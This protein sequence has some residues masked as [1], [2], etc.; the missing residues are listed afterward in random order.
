MHPEDVKSKAFVLES[1]QDTGFGTGQPY[2]NHQ[3][4]QQQQQQQL[5]QQAFQEQQHL[6]PQ[7]QQQSLYHQQQQQQQ[8]YHQQQQQQQQHQQHY[9]QQQQ[10]HFVRQTAACMSV[11]AEAAKYGNAAAIR[12]QLPQMEWGDNLTQVASDR[13][14]GVVVGGSP[15]TCPPTVLNSAASSSPMDLGGHS[16][17]HQQQQVDVVVGTAG[18]GFVHGTL[19]FATVLGGAEQRRTSVVHGGVQQQQ[20]LVP[21]PNQYSTFHDQLSYVGGGGGGGSG[22]GQ[23]TQAHFGVEPGGYGTVVQSMVQGS[24]GT[25]VIRTSPNACSPP[26]GGGTAGGGSVVALAATAYGRMEPLAPHRTTPTHVASFMGTGSPGGMRLNDMTAAATT[27]MQT[28]SPG[29][30]LLSQ[31]ATGAPL[32][33]H[34]EFV[35]P[36][37]PASFPSSVSLPTSSPHSMTIVANDPLKG[38]ATPASLYGGPIDVSLESEFTIPKVETG[39]NNQQQQQQQHQQQQQLGLSLP[40]TTDPSIHS[41]A[42]RANSSGQADDDEGEHASEDEDGSEADSEPLEEVMPTDP[43]ATAKTEALDECSLVVVKQ[44]TVSEHPG[45]MSSLGGGGEVVVAPPKRPVKHVRFVEPA[46]E[47]SFDGMAGNRARG[48]VSPHP[49]GI[50]GG[51][52]RDG[53]ED[54][55]EMDHLA[56]MENLPPV[57]SLLVE[58]D[59]PLDDEAEDDDDDDEDEDDGGGDDDDDDDDYDFECDQGKRSRKRRTPASGRGRPGRGHPA[60][61]RRTKNDESI[62]LELMEPLVPVVVEMGEGGEKAQDGGR[63]S[64]VAHVCRV[65]LCEEKEGDSS[66][67]VLESLYCTVV[68]EYQSRTL[69]SILVA[70]CHPLMLGSNAGMPDQICGTCKAKLLAAYELYDTCLRNDEMLRRKYQQKLLIASGTTRRIK[71]ETLDN[72]NGGDQDQ[73]GYEHDGVNMLFYGGTLSTRDSSK[74]PAFM[75]DHASFMMD[76]QYPLTN[77]YA[78]GRKLHAGRSSTVYQQQQQQQQATP[79]KWSK[80]PRSQLKFPHVANGPDGGGMLQHL[81]TDGSRPPPTPGGGKQTAAS[82]SAATF[83]DYNSFHRYMPNGAHQCTKCLR[84]FKYHSYFKNHFISQHDPTKPYKCRKCHYTFRNERWLIVHMRSHVCAN[85]LISMTAEGTAGFEDSATGTDDLLDESSP[86]PTGGADGEFA[87]NRCDKAFPIFDLLKRHIFEEHMSPQSRRNTLQCPYC[88]SH[89]TQQ[90]SFLRHLKQHSKEKAAAAA[91]AAAAGGR[92][93]S[94]TPTPLK[95][96]VCDIR[97]TKRASYVEHLEQ[98]H[99][100]KAQDEAHEEDDVAGGAKQPGGQRREHVCSVCSAAFARESGLNGHMADKHA[101]VLLAANSELVYVC[102]VCSAAFPDRSVLQ[103]HAETHSYAERSEAAATIAAERMDSDVKSE[104]ASKTQDGDGDGGGDGDEDEERLSEKGIK[105]E[106]GHD[107]SGDQEEDSKANVGTSL[108]ANEGDRKDLVKGEFA[109]LPEVFSEFYKCKLCLA[110]FARKDLLATHMDTHLAAMKRVSFKRSYSETGDGD[111]RLLGAVDDDDESGDDEEDDDETEGGEGAGGSGARQRARHGNGSTVDDEGE[112]DEGDGDG[113]EDEGEGTIDPEEISFNQDTGEQVFMCKVCNKVV[114]TVSQFRRHKRVHST[115]GRPFECHI[116]FYRFA[117]KY[118]YTAHMLRHEMGCDPTQPTRY[119]C[120]KCQESFTRRKLLNQH[121]VSAHGGRRM[122]SA[123]AGATGTGGRWAVMSMAAGVLDGGGGSNPAAVGPDG[124]SSGRGGHTCPICSETFTRESVLNGHMKTHTLEAAQMAH[125]EVCYLCRVCSSEFESRAQYVAHAAEAHPGTTTEMTTESGDGSAIGADELLNETAD[126][127]LGGGGLDGTKDTSLGGSP[128]VA[129]TMPA[130]GGNGGGCTLIYKCKLCSGRFMKKKSLDWH[131][132][133]HRSIVQQGDGVAMLPDIGPDV[134]QSKIFKCPVCPQMFDNEVIYS[135]HARTHQRGR[136]SRAVQSLPPAG[137]TP[138]P[139]KRKRSSWGGIIQ[140][141]L[142]KKTFTYRSQLHQHTV[143][144]HQP[145]KPYECKKCHYSFVHELNL[146]RHELTHLHDKPEPPEAAAASSSSSVVG[147]MTMLDQDDDQRH[148]QLVEDNS[149]LLQPLVLLDGPEDEPAAGGGRGDA[150]GGNHETAGSSSNDGTRG[151]W[152]AKKKVKCVICAAVFTNQNELVVH[153]QT[154]IERINDVRKRSAPPIVMPPDTGYT[155]NDRQCKLC[156]KVFKFSCLLKQHHQL[157][158]AREKP[159]ECRTCHYRF[160]YKGHLVRHR[161]NHHPNE[162]KDF[163]AG[164]PGTFVTSTPNRASPA[165]GS[166]RRSG[167]AAAAA[168]HAAATAAAAAAA[169]AM[170]VADDG[171]MGTVPKYGGMVTDEVIIAPTTT[172]SR[173]DTGVPTHQCPMCSLKFIKAR[174]LAMHMRIHLGGRKLRRVIPAT[175]APAVVTQPMVSGGDQRE[176]LVCRICSGAF[177]TTHELKTHMMTHL[178]SEAMDLEVP[179]GISAF[180][181]LHEDMF[182]D[183]LDHHGAGSSSGAGGSGAGSAAGT[184]AGNGGAGEE[185]SSS[186]GG[187]GGS[188][189]AADGGS[190]DGDYQQEGDDA[191]GGGDPLFDGS[192]LELVLEDNIFDKDFNLRY[193]QQQQQQQAQQQQVQQQ[194]RRLKGHNATGEADDDEGDEDDDDDDNEDDAT[195]ANDVDGAEDDDEEGEQSSASIASFRRTMNMS[196]MER[197]TPH[198]GR[199]RH[200][201]RSTAL[202]RAQGSASSSKSKIQCELCKKEFLYP[203]NLNQHM[204]L[205]HSKDKPHE[206]R[207]CHY[208]FEYS[209]HLQRHIRQQHEAIAEELLEPVEPQS[210]DCNFC[211]TSY[212]TRAL[213]TAHVQSQHKGEKPFQCDQCPATF[214]YKKSYETHRE[215]HHLKANN[216]AFKCSFCKKTFNSAQKV[217]NHVCIQ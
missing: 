88:Q 70:I 175:A 32:V 96:S 64:P 113:D 212:D 120:S 101:D 27:T 28:G 50:R 179:F 146:K 190:S 21:T 92:G 209:G 89:F 38:A 141:H 104:P 56:L 178:G 155:A 86:A 206:C 126:S 123:A 102:R 81:N 138:P 176:A 77:A 154:H 4:Q 217:D 116:C 19:P 203:C 109:D 167:A 153:L 177:P 100:L 132:K 208:R 144:H 69:Y 45:A 140:C 94:V 114:G 99:G 3:Q 112:E 197:A 95:C 210:F 34:G 163:E 183:S 55:E 51:H 214:S 23:A 97:F 72:R 2:L 63:L 168:A 195:D 49:L 204:Q 106:S 125:S 33:V 59:G 47:N 26:G 105:R 79:K 128:N 25:V 54:D 149:H 29:T 181:M 216:G 174:S 185:H 85:T 171:T 12:S 31:R 17:L 156:H 129:L 35:S 158:H 145:G 121:V 162:P 182:N 164:G 131:L 52:G 40:L 117:M 134:E 71:K 30:S 48:T 189:R 118:S 159:F 172:T 115:K 124:A 73:D 192:N 108:S 215:E 207:V 139:T 7:Q 170:L 76:K 93:T 8:H 98:K 5:Y 22:G 75:K 187:E 180:N 111:D 157:H 147:E 200:S 193:Q 130:T 9:Q 152:G 148:D 67:R 13:G 188:S 165:V 107:D 191:S 90:T 53:D 16:H 41:A 62:E 166:G 24:P 60:T 78:M 18:T 42:Q 39:R 87:C 186:V 202:G 143:L 169:A 61:S 127:S 211:G 133:T 84:E 37:R 82:R 199:A 1:V 11:P 122:K 68:P 43:L 184:S 14:V 74:R 161:A 66:V 10:Q 135:E 213:L 58:M 91:A 173:S 198:S 150:D 137:Y 142:C 136:P 57:E 83:Y 46:E 44:D 119:R 205:H 6:H 80:Y 160:E 36:S 20:H 194:Q 110:R 15:L 151:T 196:I 65:C 201:A 103:E